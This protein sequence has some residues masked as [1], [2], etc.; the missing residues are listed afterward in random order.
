MYVDGIGTFYRGSP[1]GYKVGR[2]LRA[3]SILDVHMAGAL[4]HPRGWCVSNWTL[5]D[6]GFLLV[7]FIDAFERND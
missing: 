1:A 5:L 4:P 2:L 7:A 3:G 6:V